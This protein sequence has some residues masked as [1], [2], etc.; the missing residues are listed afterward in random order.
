MET[1]AEGVKLQKGTSIQTPCPPC[2]MGKRHKLPFGR[3]VIRTK[4]GEKI[5]LDISGPN[6]VEALGKY[7][8]FA[9]FTDDASRFTWVYLLCQKDEIGNAFKELV[10]WLSQQF[11]YKV[12]HVVG[13]NAGEHESIKSFCTQQGIQ[14][15]LIP[16]YLSELNGVAEIKNRNLI[17]PLVV[18]MI[19]NQLPKYLWA[20]LLLGV[21]FTMNRLW[22]LTIEMT[23]YEALYGKKPDISSL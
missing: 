3:R 21:N 17:E 5:H 13:D 23:P 2:L 20:N 11:G 8:Y 15:N 18:V 19:E 1:S 6:L 14:W 4:P 7:R 10:S 16:P 12:K 9:T 22:N